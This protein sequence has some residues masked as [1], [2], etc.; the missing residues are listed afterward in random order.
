MRLVRI[1]LT[2][3]LAALLVLAA[4]GV[5]AGVLVLRS[6]WFRERVRTRIVAEVSRATGGQVELGQF[7]FDWQR[8]VA[9]VGPLIVRGKEPASERP[10]LRLGYVS[11]G[12]RV[13]SAF[14]RKVDLATLRV[15][16]PEVRIVVY[17]DGSTN[18]PN[19][20]RRTTGNWAQQLLNLKVQSYEITNGIFEFDQRRT[21]L[22]LA[23]DDLE[24]QMTYDAETPSYRGTFASQRLRVIPVGRG[25]IEANVRSRFS[26]DKDKFLFPQIDIETGET[27]IQARGELLDVRAPHGSF[28]VQANVSVREAVRTFAIPIGAQGS[29]TFAGKLNVGFAPE[30]TFSMNGKATARGIRYVQDR[31]RIEDASFSSDI[32]IEKDGL[33]LDA[34]QGQALGAEVTGKAALTGNWRRFAMDGDIANMDVHRAAAI[35]TD[36]AVPW[37]GTLSG[38][39]HVDTTI[40]WR[41]ARGRDAKLN[42]KLTVTPA[43]TGAP[44]EGSIDANYDQTAGTLALGSSWIATPASRLE[45]SGTLGQKLQVRLRTNNADDLLPALAMAQQ[46]AP[47]ALPL[48]LINGVAIAEGVVTGALDD[49]HFSGQINAT[50]GSVEGHAFDRFA[51]QLEADRREVRAE[52]VALARGNT[53]LTGAATLTASNGSFDDAALTATANAKGIDIAAALNELG[54]TFEASGTGSAT[55]RIA[56]SLKAP[57]AEIVAEVERP[58]A[59]GETFT[60]LRTTLRYKPDSVEIVSGEASDAAGIVRFGGKYTRAGNDWKSGEATW[61]AA[62]QNF[63]AGRLDRMA[64]VQPSVDAA[65]TGRVRGAA[66]ISNGDFLLQSLTADLAADR[67]M[68]DKKPVGEVS[69]GL[70][71]RGSELQMLATGKI[72]ESTVESRGM[73]TLS[74]TYP[75]T[76]TVRFSR[77]SIASIHDVVNIL[78]GAN[79][80]EINEDPFEGFL[81]GS[82]TFSLPLRSLKDLNAQVTLDTLQVNPKPTQALR[83]GVQPQDI[84]LKNERPVLLD[85]TSQDIRVRQARFTGRDT[86]LEASGAIPLQGGA[87]ADLSLRGNVNLILLQLYSPDLLARG[88]ASVQAAIR[89]SLQS[90]QI[91]GRLELKGTSLYFGDLPNGIDNANGS[92]L[93]DRNRA[94]IEKL[95]AET[96]GG[97]ISLTGTLE[98]GKTLV[99]RLQATAQQVRVRWPEDLSTTYNARLGLVGTPESSTLSGTLT[100]TRAAFNPRTD[101]GQLLAQ[102]SKPTPAPSA[103]NEILRGM[104]FDVRVESGPNFTFETSLTRDVEAEVDLNLHGTPVRPVLLGN[105][106]VNRGEVQ[107]FGSRYTIGRGEVHFLNPVKIEPSFDMDLETRA[108]GITVNVSFSGT[109]Q[110]LKVNYSSDPP[111]QSSEIIALLAVGRDPTSATNTTVGSPTS[112]AGGLVAA[113]SGLLGQAVNAQISSRLQRF[114]GASRVKIDPTLTGVDN[115]PQARLTIEQQVTKD[116]TLTY[117]TNLNRTQEQV[118]RMQWDLDRNWSAIFL[119]D[120]NGFYGLDFQFR[121]RF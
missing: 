27:K 109:M 94:T 78:G 61:D 4:L 9:D 10:F 6:G 28:D 93:F 108:R 35:F 112:S 45:L 89:G 97:T 58:S 96:G 1:V 103:P 92:V 5:L 100:V 39:F 47:T 26:L 79:E 76:G 65:V 21:P 117:I 115:L 85:V 84:V 119:R 53:E 2:R 20:G 63:A 8:M 114:F 67:L 75:G 95:T 60:R 33:T 64:T 59:Y 42:A 22:N 49:P 98:F 88:D 102:A 11:L 43:A 121:K 24:V 104:Q 113:G 50:N 73:W 120:P 105:V 46:N 106:T 15:D 37:G 57:Q 17:P 101:L 80:A 86:S 23:G 19:P 69:L 29:A 111:L 54:S 7:N 31:L 77:M 99:Y 48:K 52:R 87:Q 62:T 107:V 72:R 70:E 51:T 30:F 3:T 91:N 83:L 34:I 18:I 40:P 41:G 55:A 12:L 118:V 56:G 66:R 74:G 25:P 13:I 110:Q 71:T 16:G 68:V 81:E 36:R 44:L 38:P 90:P 14:E 82:A 32:D 116:I